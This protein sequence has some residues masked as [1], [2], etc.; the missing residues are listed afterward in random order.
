MNVKADRAVFIQYTQEIPGS[1]PG[2]KTRYSA[3]KAGRVGAWV[4]S[5]PTPSPPG[6][7]WGRA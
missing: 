2:V 4:S 6:K 7:F 1:N 3:W 5:A